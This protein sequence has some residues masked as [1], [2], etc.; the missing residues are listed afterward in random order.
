MNLVA[1]LDF[2]WQLSHSST[3]LMTLTETL[4]SGGVPQNV[5]K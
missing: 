2:R 3:E 1:M 4:F 5:S